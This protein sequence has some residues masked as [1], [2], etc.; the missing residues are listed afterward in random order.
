MVLR[1][2]VVWLLLLLLAIVNGAFREGFLNPSLGP[3]AGHIASTAMLSMMILIVARLS[4]AW[5]GTRTES[6]AVSVG[7][8]WVALVLA[9]E[10]LAGHFLFGRSWEYLLADYDLLRGRVWILVP[11]VTLLAPWWAH[12]M[13]AVH[14]LR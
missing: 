3:I 1:A 7:V 9:F 4:T 2:L 13:T 5:I 6:D 12:R 8:L 10:F 11:I 14:S